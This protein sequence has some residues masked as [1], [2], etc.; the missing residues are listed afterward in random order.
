[1]NGELEKYQPGWLTARLKR[2]AGQVMRL[3]WPATV[4]RLGGM[5]LALI[6][7]IMV[8]R[9]G[10]AE[11]AY[12]QIASG[13]AIMVV[14]TVAIGLV[15]GTLIY[16]ARAYGR[17]DFA[18]CGQ[19][20]RRSM[21]FSL[22]VGVPATFVMIPGE[23]LLT[24]AGQT[25]EVAAAGGR[26]MTV[27]AYGSIGHILWVASVFFLEGVERPKVG[28]TIALAGNLLNVALNYM[29]VYG[30]WGFPAMGAE[31]SAWATSI[32]RLTMAG[33]IILYILT[34]PSLQRYRPANWS[35]GRWAEWR[36][37]RHMGYANAVS[38]G[39]EVGAFAALTI[40]A[41]FLGTQSLAAFGIIF[42][43]MAMSFMVA[44][45]FGSAGSVRVGIAA[46]RGDADD[47]ALA[48]WTALGLTFILLSVVGLLIALFSL[49]VTGFA[50]SDMALIAF[51]APVLAY[52]VLVNVIDGGQ[53]VLS[54]VLRGL[55][56]TWVPTAIQSFTYIVVML[57]LSYWLALGL[58]Q[59]IWGLINAALAAS[60][61]SVLLQGWRFH[62]SARKV[63]LSG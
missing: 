52:S 54:N 37:L 63:G 21:V 49:K 1:M 42:Q 62:V 9:Y 41:G 61:I 46:A 23:F 58:R 32:L 15:I 5:T 44:L 45:G 40:F 3:A 59:G 13:T 2:H 36:K 43:V 34:A 6:D 4:A 39:A 56:E 28:M 48:G 27:L 60:V 50:S 47:A 24:L 57:P 22:L 26:V 29:L 18:E 53:A 38:M 20:W 7:I 35:L 12:L 25:P 14:L 31:G 8:G 30:H 55:G 10:T 17:G 16:T 33:A 11:L 51:A 19:V